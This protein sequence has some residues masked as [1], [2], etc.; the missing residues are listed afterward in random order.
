MS[1]SSSVIW[2]VYLSTF[3]NGLLI[4]NNSYVKFNLYSFFSG[5][6]IRVEQKHLTEN[7]KWRFMN[8]CL[9]KQ[10]IISH[11]LFFC[12]FSLGTLRA[13]MNAVWPLPFVQKVNS[14]PRIFQVSCVLI[15]H[16]MSSV[17]QSCIGFTQKASP[18]MWESLK[19]LVYALSWVDK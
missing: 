14:L 6:K 11:K 16:V 9:M 10:S 19:S 5:M 15:S 13:V 2:S 18:H 1:H 3:S 7:L 17:W 4:Q 8:F 12:V